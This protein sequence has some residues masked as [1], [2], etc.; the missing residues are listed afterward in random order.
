MGNPVFRARL[1]NGAVERE[2]TPGVH[3]VGRSAENNIQLDD[4]SVSRRHARIVVED[5][6]IHVED[7][8]SSGGTSAGGQRLPARTPHAL[9]EGEG[10]R[11]GDVQV[12]IGLP[13]PE[14]PPE[15]PGPEAVPDPAVAT[16]LAAAAAYI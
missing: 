6:A 11:F 14:T 10:L 2:L 12:E 9:G 8:G 7:L 16:E 3:T 13:A 15:P 5:G 4:L 1:A